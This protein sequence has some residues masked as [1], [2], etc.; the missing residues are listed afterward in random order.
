M[1]SC[2]RDLSQRCSSL[3][4]SAALLDLTL[5]GGFWVTV[6][7]IKGMSLPYWSLKAY[8]QKSASL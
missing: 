1:G 4:F 6:G 7:S 8:V 5:I 3:R 2:P